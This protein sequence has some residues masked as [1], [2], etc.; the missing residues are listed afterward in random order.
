MSIVNCTSC[1]AVVV[2]RE[3]LDTR[4]MHIHICTK[5]IHSL[6]DIAGATVIQFGRSFS[7][8]ANHNIY[9][10]G[11]QLP[12]YQNKPIIEDLVMDMPTDR[13]RHR[14]EGGDQLL[15]NKK[16][17]MIPHS[18]K[19][20]LGKHV[21]RLTVDRETY[22]QICSISP[23]VKEW[24]LGGNFCAPWHGFPVLPTM[25]HPHITQYPN[26]REPFRIMIPQPSRFSRSGHHLISEL[27]GDE[28]SIAGV[29]EERGCY[30]LMV[31]CQ[32][33]DKI[34]GIAQRLVFRLPTLFPSL[35][36]DAW[37][38][39]MPFQTVMYPITVVKS[40]KQYWGN[41]QA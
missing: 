14:A 37:P 7:L 30:G 31:F 3:T 9:S 12:M 22:D 18:N 38:W 1:G 25:T 6:G 35:R 39:T 28:S 27:C 34:K 17:M 23:T 20:I 26:H 2:M 5:I 21:A 24:A 29:Q 40:G 8:A 36:V 19:D 41:V 32:E 33:D 16:K 4:P 11:T 13:K 10:K 15:S